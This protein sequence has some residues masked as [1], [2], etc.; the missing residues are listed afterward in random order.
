MIISKKKLMTALLV[1][2]MMIGLL[3]AV[4]L[5]AMA[6]TVYADFD[7]G[8]NDTDIIPDGTAIDGLKF[9][10][11]YDA[12]MY[13]HDQGEGYDNSP[14]LYPNVIGENATW[15]SFSLADG[16]DFKFVSFWIGANY[17]SSSITVE[18]YL[19]ELKKYTTG[20]TNNTM[21]GG[22]SYAFGWAKVDTVKVIANYSMDT[23]NINMVTDLYCV[24]DHIGYEVV[25]D[26]TTAPT[27]AGAQRDSATQITVALSEPCQN[28]TQSTDGGF[29]VTK[30][31]DASTAYAVS[32]TAQ[33]ED[34]SHVRLTVADLSAAAS[35]GVK[36][37]YSS[38]G[39]GT[40]A[41]L[42]GNEMATNTTGV[43]IAAWD[44]TAPTVLSINRQDPIAVST[45]AESVV[46]RVTFSEAVTGV[47][48]TDFSLY[49]DGVTGTIASVSAGEGTAI[50]VTVNG[51]S[52]T[53]T[54]RLDLY[55]AGTGITD[56]GGL[57]LN[58]GFI[59]QM[60]TVDDTTAP[61][62]VSAQRSSVT[63]FIVTLSEPCRNLDQA[64]NGGFAM[65]ATGDSGKT[66]EITKTEQGADASHI[67][68]TASVPETSQPGSTGVTITYTADGGT[69]ADDVGNAMATDDTGVIIPPWDTTA[70]TVVSINRYIPSQEN[71]NAYLVEFFLSFSEPVYINSFSNFSVTT[72]GT[73]TCQPVMFHPSEGMA[74]QYYYFLVGMIRGEGTIRL[75]ILNDSSIKDY[76]GNVLAGGFTDGQI[77]K[78][79]TVAPTLT[80]A[81]QD[82]NTQ[83]TVTLS[84]ACQ[85]LTKDNDGGFSVVSAGDTYP[86]T[87]IAQGTD[88]SHVVLTVAD[89]GTAAGRTGVTVTYAEGVTGT[90]TDTT[91]NALATDST[92]VAV[93]ALDTTAP[94]IVGAVLDSNT[95]ITLLM[96]ED[97]LNADKPNDGGF[98][99]TMTGTTITFPVQSTAHGSIILTVADMSAAGR[100]GVTITYTAGGNGTITDRAGNPMASTGTQGAVRLD[101]WDTASPQTGDTARPVLWILLLAGAAL[102]AGGLVWWYSHSKKKTK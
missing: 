30:T 9:E 38:D 62:L 87:K 41:D 74:S 51:I 97:C 17:G 72:T 24:F 33:G 50:D 14:A 5:R 92:G 31:G 100:A 78:V 13:Y 101:A 40:I 77:Y 102:L 59:G 67:V 45:N 58:G 71:T 88:A 28:L 34:T 15:I 83:I 27:L 99:V 76:N 95:Q 91:G 25:A 94:S 3:P 52:G 54:L 70:P 7:T 39:N 68:L 86:V 4:T 79:D 21:V 75:D 43:S 18:G 80:G 23:G 55:A 81:V 89:M 20:I 26:D 16:S 63:Q 56:R 69:V 57:P 19:D 6:A 64:D 12:G 93:A 44:T 73:V 37:T 46:Y 32:A 48:T 36:V 53:G 29:T 47:D 35:T 1:L 65:Y 96:S 60:Y 61:T 2:T 84:E 11:A 22:Q 90:V 98:T 10:V 66:Y 8:Y 49:K 85:N 82:S 42:A